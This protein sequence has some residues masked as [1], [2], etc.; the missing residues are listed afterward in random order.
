MRL[1]CR[2]LDRLEAE[3]L[4][5]L[6]EVRVAAQ[7]RD[8]TVLCRARSNQGV[9]NWDAVVS[10]AAFSQL[11]ESAH[12]RKHRWQPVCLCCRG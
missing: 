3:N 5:E 1:G 8:A 7:D 4:C 11:A 12:C 10:V 6:V 9:G 2:E